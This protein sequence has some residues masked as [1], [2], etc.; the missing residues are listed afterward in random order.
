MASL[1]CKST[2]RRTDRQTVRS[3]YYFAGTEGEWSNIQ[4]RRQREGGKVMGE[5][6]K[7]QSMIERYIKL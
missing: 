7:I 1:P 6:M 2:G 4:Q 3:L 5:E